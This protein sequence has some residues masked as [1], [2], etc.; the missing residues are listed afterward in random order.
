MTIN[1]IPSKDPA[2]DGDLGGVFGFI[3]RKHMQVVQ[4]QLPA[5]VLSYDRVTNTANVRP[6]VALMTTEGDSIQRASIARVPVVSF[7]GAGYVINFPLKPGDLGWIEASDRDISLFMQNLVESA[8]NTKRMHS[9]EDARFLPDIMRQYTIDNEDSE[10]MVIQTTDATV[11]IVLDKTTQEVRITAPKMK[12]TV[13]DTTWEGNIT[14]TGDITQTG[15]HDVTGEVTANGIPLST[16]KTLG[17]TPGSG[18]SG[19]PTT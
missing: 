16:H 7:G 2:N 15:D 4:G 6:L 11:R 18:I 17:V 3:L 19:L 5:Q 12:V 14:I 9:F 8:P 13:P 10:A 1:A